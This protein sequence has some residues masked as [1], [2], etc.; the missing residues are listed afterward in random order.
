M[1]R[2]SEKHHWDDFWADSQNLE[3]VYGTDD[4]IFEQLKA[5]IGLEGARVIEIGAGTGRDT[6]RTAEAGAEAYALDYSETSLTLMKG[7]LAHD[8]GLICGDAFNLPFRDETFDV[9]F[10]QGL[11]E[12]FRNPGDLIAE[13]VRILK[14][15][16][17]LL[18]D[19]PQRF[20][21]YTLAKHILIAM[22]KWFA[23]W[24]TE[25][26]VGQLHGLMEARGVRVIGVYGH[27]QFPPI[28]Y[29]GIRRVLLKADVRLPM[30]PENAGL[31]RLRLWLRSLVPHGLY[32]NTAM[33]I[34]CIAKKD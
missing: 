19:V 17:I 29:R 26:S 18:I 23:G 8:V 22:G 6:D 12:H 3:D 1:K 31:R 25:F 9:V 32:V 33:V 7:S 21:Y 24:E 10:H 14:R 16:G 27:N 30:Y 13:N 5:Y 34:G 15:G 28:W 20:H 11:L 2:T 4:R